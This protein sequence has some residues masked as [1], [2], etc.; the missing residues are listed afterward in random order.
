[1]HNQELLNNYFSN[2]WKTGNTRGITSPEEISKYIK[3]DEWVLDVG[4]GENPFK[5]LLTN[6]VGI[7]PAFSQADFRCTIEEYVPDRL[8]DVATC[9]GSIN[10]GGI[11]TIEKQID[12]VVACLKPKSRIYWRLNPG[13]HDHNNAEC[14]G[15]PFFPWSF[16]ILRTFAEKHN[17]T[18]TLEEI[19]SHV[20]RPRLYAE[21]HRTS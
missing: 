16:E 8:F 20:S 17:Y 9:L 5:K 7:D 12:S 2:H 13:R 1:M 15:I 6:V 21:W 3:E 18:Q 10:F 4:C 14:A 19:D 11:E